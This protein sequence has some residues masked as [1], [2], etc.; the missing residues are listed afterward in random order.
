MIIT[1]VTALR[2]ILGVSARQV[3]R[4][5]EKLWNTIFKPVLIPR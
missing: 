2:G 3:C 1:R 4:F 5:K